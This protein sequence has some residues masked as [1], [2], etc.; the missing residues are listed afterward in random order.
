MI[1]LQYHPDRTCRCGAALVRPEGS[2][3]GSPWRCRALFLG[4]ACP[5]THH[6]ERDDEAPGAEAPAP[7]T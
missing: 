1:Q 4:Y 7:S 5:G 2:P 6:D 3:A